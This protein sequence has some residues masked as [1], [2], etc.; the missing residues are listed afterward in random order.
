MLY[1]LSPLYAICIN[2]PVLVAYSR[3][4]FVLYTQ[5]KNALTTVFAIWNLEYCNNSE[6][7]LRLVHRPI[8]V[9]D[10]YSSHDKEKEQVVLYL[11]LV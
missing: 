8:I 7:A 5:T 2:F 6:V 1:P 11:T 3:I 9:D 4:C 10:S